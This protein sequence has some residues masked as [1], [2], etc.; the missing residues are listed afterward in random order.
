MCGE[1]PSDADQ[2]LIAAAPDLLA[3]LEAINAHWEAGNFS[4]Q[5]HLW[6]PMKAAIAKAK[7]GAA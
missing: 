3:A 6:E 7:G 5:P 2:V 4:R 1:E